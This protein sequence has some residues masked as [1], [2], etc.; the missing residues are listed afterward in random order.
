LSIILSLNGFHYL[1]HLSITWE[2]EVVG[3][4]KTALIE[5]AKQTVKH[6]SPSTLGTLVGRSTSHMRRAAAKKISKTVGHPL[7]FLLDKT[8]KFKSSKGLKHSELINRPAIVEMGHIT[9]NLAGRQER[10]ML[11]AAWENQFNRVT[12]EG[13]GKGVFVENVAIDIG[14]IAV[15]LKS[16][17]W[18]EQLG[19]LAQGTVANAPRLVF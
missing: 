5:T 6:A 12:A 9:S 3:R 4:P 8:G 2:Q 15:D 16:A 17:L 11:Q 13:I 10:I 7:K 18:W 19:L 14:G 1:K